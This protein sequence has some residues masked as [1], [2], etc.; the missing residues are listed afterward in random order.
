MLR[1]PHF[2]KLLTA[3]ALALALAMILPVLAA[4]ANA[5]PLLDN[6]NACGEP[7]YVADQLIVE[8]AWPPG[9]DETD[10]ADADARVQQIFAQIPLEEDDEAEEAEALR[11][12]QLPPRSGKSPS[13]SVLVSLDGGVGPLELSARLRQLPAVWHAR[14]NFLYPLDAACEDSELPAVAGFDAE[15]SLVAAPALA[16]T[17]R[18]LLRYSQDGDEDSATAE[19]LEEAVRLSFMEIGLAGSLSI[20]VLTGVGL[21]VQSPEIPDARAVAGL[22]TALED[23]EW[24]QPDPVGPCSLEEAGEGLGANPC[25]LIRDREGERTLVLFSSNFIDGPPPTHASGGAWNPGWA[26]GILMLWGLRRRQK[27]GRVLEI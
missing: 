5:M 3:P 11:F 13:L 25:G 24:A 22:L 21:R 7:L 1:L 12:K 26:W 4:P 15:G 16:T 18:L 2:E 20:Q 19:E 9:D 17:D 14:P 23:I 27:I 8:F 10:L 6:E